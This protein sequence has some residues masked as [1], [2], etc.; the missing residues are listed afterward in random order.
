M[1]FCWPFSSHNCHMREIGVNIFPTDLVYRSAIYPQWKTY[2]YGLGGRLR[3]NRFLPSEFSHKNPDVRVDPKS[4][5]LVF[6]GR[7]G[8]L[9]AVCSKQEVSWLH[10]VHHMSAGFRFRRKSSPPNIVNN[11]L[12]MGLVR[13]SLQPSFWDTNHK[14]M[15]RYLL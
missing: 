15:I 12:H 13:T 7:R 3:K 9:D 14:L 2:K 11:T 10:N 8:S 1:A 4:V 6:I 5:L